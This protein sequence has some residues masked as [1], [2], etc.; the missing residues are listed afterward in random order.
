MCY[1]IDQMMNEGSENVLLLRYEDLALEPMEWATRVFS[2]VEMDFDSEVSD[3]I[4]SQ[5]SLEKE[6]SDF[7][8]TK[9]NPKTV[10]LK[11]RLKIQESIQFTFKIATFKVMQFLDFQLH[12]LLSNSETCFQNNSMFSFWASFLNCLILKVNCSFG[13]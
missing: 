6:S 11:E 12:K 8:S 2:F 9:H 13:F 7:Y 1:F 3:W 10:A 4:K 5:T